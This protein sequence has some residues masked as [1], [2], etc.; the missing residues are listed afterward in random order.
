MPSTI[1]TGLRTAGIVLLIYTGFG[2]VFYL[3]SDTYIFHPPQQSKQALPQS[4]FISTPAGKINALYLKPPHPK[5]TILFSHGNA[6]D[7]NR[8]APWL[9]LLQQQGY[10]VMGYDYNGYGFSEGQPSESHCYLDASASYRYLRQHLHVPAN[11]II[12]MAHSLGTGVAVN[13]AT[14]VPYAGMILESPLLS[15]Y[16]VVMFRGWPLFPFDKF[17]NASKISSV[18]QPLFILHGTH[19]QVIP[20][21][22]GVKLYRLANQPKFFYAIKGAGHNNLM[23]GQYWQKINRF[24]RYATARASQASAP[25]PA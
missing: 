13:L 4:F 20:F 15:A 3:L 7:L 6:S 2:L 24:I 12:L 25:Q 5:A 8:I 19:D 14:K 11:R 1:K 21:I 18:H 10:A 9:N 22:H 17:D 16:R 23:S